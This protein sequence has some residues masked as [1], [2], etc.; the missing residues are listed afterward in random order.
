MTGSLASYL[1]PSMH[2]ARGYSTRAFLRYVSTSLAPTN[3]PC[4]PGI[5]MGLNLILLIALP[6]SAGEGRNSR[7][8]R[9]VFLERERADGPR[10]DALARRAEFRP[11]VRWRC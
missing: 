4:A 5:S 8:G 9:A 11:D 10:A 6:L 2:W 1:A 7:R 3:R